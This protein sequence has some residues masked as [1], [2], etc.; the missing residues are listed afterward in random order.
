MD[1]GTLRIVGNGPGLT[2]ERGTHQ[3]T[4]TFNPSPERIPVRGEIQISNWKHAGLQTDCRPFV[5]VAPSLGSAWPRQ[6]ESMLARSSATL[7]RQLDCLPSSGLVAIHAG[8]QLAERVSI[9]RMPL[10]PSFVRSSDMSPRKPLPCAF[11]N[12]LGER[13][14]ALSILRDFGSERLFWESFFLEDV[15]DFG[16][17]ADFNPLERLVDVFSQGNSVQECELIETLE[18]L[19]RVHTTTWIRNADSSCLKSLERFFFLGRNSS[20][21]PK[22][23]LFNNRISSLLDDILYKLMRCQLE[24]MDR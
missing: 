17:P 23:W 10:K 6:F 18:R 9:Y 20:D 7:V 4:I 2:E 3:L 21:T 22:G 16:Q 15:V 8:L 1:L 5:V 14:I 24:L 13:R 12:W 19:S 11:H